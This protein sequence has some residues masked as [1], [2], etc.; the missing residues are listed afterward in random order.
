MARE[1]KKYPGKQ[2]FVSYDAPEVVLKRH[3]EILEFRE[4]GPE[5]CVIVNMQ[6]PPAKYDRDKGFKAEYEV[7]WTTAKGWQC[8]MQHSGC[9]APLPD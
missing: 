7:H 1:K 5:E 2:F 3:Q 4:A 8:Y 9:Y 6:A